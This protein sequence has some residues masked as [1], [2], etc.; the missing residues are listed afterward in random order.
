VR[1]KGRR[2]RLPA[3]A[4]PSLSPLAHSPRG[5]L[6]RTADP[7]NIYEEPSQRP[8]SR[9]KS[10]RPCK[11]KGATFTIV[12]RPACTV[13]RQLRIKARS[14]GFVRRALGAARFAL[15]KV[16]WRRS[17]HAERRCLCRMVSERTV[18]TSRLERY[19]RS[20]K[21]RTDRRYRRDKSG[22]STCYRQRLP[23]C[24]KFR[25]GARPTNGER[26]PL[27]E[28][29]ARSPSYGGL[30]VGTRPN[31]GASRSGFLPARCHPRYPAARL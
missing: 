8:Y 6:W 3:R 5:L 13:L 31:L 19:L 22:Q 11:A 7:E 2:H 12:L 14:L 23:H 24:F 4:A 1:G 25:T 29:A 20:W 17:R 18:R 9:R 15:N 28:L 16:P 10:H 21:A 30:T 27:G 26:R